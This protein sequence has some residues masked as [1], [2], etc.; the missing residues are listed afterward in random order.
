MTE[1]LNP[2]QI[3]RD[4]AMVGFASNP[5]CRKCPRDDDGRSTPHPCEP[6]RLAA[7]LIEAKRVLGYFGDQYGRLLVAYESIVMDTPEDR[8]LH[9]RSVA[10]FKAVVGM[11]PEREAAAIR[12]AENRLAP[13]TGISDAELAADLLD[14][15]L[16]PPEGGPQ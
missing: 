16:L 4:H 12:E 6:Y 3:M 7:A 11:T 10:A 14:A 13:G 2:A 15:D 8:D 9:A 1:P 5:R